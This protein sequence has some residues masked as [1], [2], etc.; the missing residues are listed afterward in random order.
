MT[1]SRYPIGDTQVVVDWK[2]GNGC[3]G[4]GIPQSNK[5]SV[6]KKQICMLSLA[7]PSMH[8]LVKRWREMLREIVN[9][10]HTK[11]GSWL[12]SPGS[13]GCGAGDITPLLDLS[14]MDLVDGGRKT[15]LFC[16]LWTRD[17]SKRFESLLFPV[18][19]SASETSYC[20]KDFNV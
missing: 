11:Y 17:A 19:F 6:G 8:P 9:V 13:F 16:F 4:F 1:S 20:M 14:F 3:E 7:D 15:L 2:Q 5:L 10:H 12:P 18:I